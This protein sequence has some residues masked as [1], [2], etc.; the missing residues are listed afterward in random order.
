MHNTTGKS[1]LKFG[2]LIFFIVVSMSLVG[3]GGG[4]VQTDPFSE[5]VNTLILKIRTAHLNS[6]PIAI[7]NLA[8][9]PVTEIWQQ[10]DGS[11]IQ[12]FVNYTE[13]QYRNYWA[14]FSPKYKYSVYTVSNITCQSS[15]GTTGVVN[16]IVHCTYVL[17]E[18][19]VSEVW[20]CSMDLVRDSGTWKF[21][22]WLLIKQN[23]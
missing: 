13:T 9:Y 3:C 5:E 1:L 22:K 14:D 20:N 12:N 8:H 4:T 17:N 21:S 7:P 2:F 23:L 6:D 19:T 10:K 11:I 18:N 15:S 16:F